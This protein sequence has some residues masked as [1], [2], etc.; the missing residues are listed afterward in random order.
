MFCQLLKNWHWPQWMAES[1]FDLPGCPPDQITFSIRIAS[2]FATRSVTKTAQ[3]STITLWP[4]SNHYDIYD[5]HGLN[6]CSCL[7]PGFLEFQV[8]CLILWDRRQVLDPTCSHTAPWWKIG[9]ASNQ[10][11]WQMQTSSSR[12]FIVW[13]LT[14]S[15]NRIS[16]CHLL[17]S[18]SCLVCFGTLAVGN[19]E[20]WKKA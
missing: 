4:V 15:L 2:T 17:G 1:S 19:L 10:P 6:S 12:N 11:F 14:S 8:Q 7:V 13:A 20:G 9:C 5:H 16:K 3:N 18:Y